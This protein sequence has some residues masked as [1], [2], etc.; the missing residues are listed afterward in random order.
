MA[1]ITPNEPGAHD[2]PAAPSGWDRA[3]R[4]M[5]AGAALL[6]AVSGLVSALGQA[7]WS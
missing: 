7:P 2:V 1:T 3:V 5:W 4:L 6:T